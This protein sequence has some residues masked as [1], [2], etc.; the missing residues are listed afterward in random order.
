MIEANKTLKSYI[1]QLLPVG[2]EYLLVSIGCLAILFGVTV[3]DPL[4]NIPFA[5]A[6]VIFGY[7]LATYV[8]KGGAVTIHYFTTTNHTNDEKALYQLVVAF[9]SKKLLK[10]TT[11]MLI[12]VISIV[13]FL[14]YAKPNVFNI[15]NI[16]WLIFWTTLTML[17]L[18]NG[19]KYVSAWWNIRRNLKKEAKN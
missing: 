6:G 8:N 19:V 16:I 10:L 3:T 7:Y 18:G 17:M 11:V 1:K 14:H 13:N 15:N 5:I 4:I 12:L 2:I 9:K